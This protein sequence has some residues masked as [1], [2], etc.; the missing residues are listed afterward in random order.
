MAAL[1]RLGRI[2][3]LALY[4]V[5]EEFGR[6][7]LPS[8]LVRQRNDRFTSRDEVVAYTNATMDRYKHGDLHVLRQWFSTYLKADLRVECDVYGSAHP[9][10]VIAHRVDQYGFLAVQRS[11][12]DIIE[13]FTLS[14]YDLGAA[15]VDTV[16]LTKRGQHPEITIPGYLSTPTPAANFATGG[17]SVTHRVAD[18]AGVRIPPTD[19]TALARVQ[20]R[21][22]PAREWGFDKE[23]DCL[24]WVTVKDDGDYAA[25]PTSRTWIP[26]TRKMLVRKIDEMIA[27]D[28]KALRELRGP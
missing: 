1:N 18:V 21:R 11:D 27:E 17:I 23:A 16:K 12:D 25:V 15:I 8:P 10:R 6:D 7:F 28:V 24:Q 26:M 4:V 20:S 22:G 3:L 9:L 19:V 5:G 13:I 14:P 2:D